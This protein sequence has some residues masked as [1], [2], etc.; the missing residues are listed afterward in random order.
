MSAEATASQRSALSRFAERFIRTYKSR[1]S[2]RLGAHCRFEPTCSEYGLEAY[3]RYGFLHA[4]VK[5]LW[6]VVRC[7]PLTR[8]PKYDPA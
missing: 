4:T 5:T 1:V 8:G 3:R 6:R 2:P 7:N